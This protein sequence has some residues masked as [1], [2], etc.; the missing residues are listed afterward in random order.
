M[1]AASSLK[2]IANPLNKEKINLESN[3]HKHTEIH[4]QIDGINKNV[5]QKNH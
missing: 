1:A 4:I 3:T 5:T 2:Q